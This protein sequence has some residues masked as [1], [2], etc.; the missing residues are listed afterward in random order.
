ML[1]SK[2]KIANFISEAVKFIKKYGFDGLDLDYEYPN[3]DGVS[4]DI[5]GFTQLVKGLRKAFKPYGWELTAAVGAA[6]KTVEQGYEVAKIAKYLDFINLMTYDLHGSWEKTADHQ[7]PLYERKFEPGSFLT[8]DYAVNLWLKLGTPR[9]KLMVGIPTYGRSFTLAGSK[10]A[11]PAPA[12]D[13]GKAGPVTRARG[14]LSYQ[15]ICLDVKNNGWT[16][17]SDPTKKMGP[18]AYKG[19]QWVGYDDPA[20]AEYKA[21]YIIKNNLGGAM[22]WDLPS[23]DFSNRCGNGKYPIIQRVADTL[24]CK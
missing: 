8:V 23:D 5:K 22:F 17:V 2:E 7:A 20:M 16:K 11:P 14:F 15:E 21:K 12:K 4:T 13:A 19:N 3:Y 18:Y 1:A 9:S 24:A 10:T 6:K